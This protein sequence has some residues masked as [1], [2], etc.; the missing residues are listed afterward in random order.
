MPGHA[1]GI[2]KQSSE[3]N[4]PSPAQNAGRPGPAIAR[5]SP[6]AAAHF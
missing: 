4:R 1:P 3:K 6:S 5:P 2:L